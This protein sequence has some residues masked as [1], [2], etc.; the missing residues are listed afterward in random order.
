MC[1]LLFIINNILA[2][3]M[4]YAEEILQNKIYMV[5]MLKNIL[6][7]YAKIIVKNNKKTTQ[8]ARIISVIVIY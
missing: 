8:D 2:N 1:W 7:N 4:Q 5:K 3:I 6:G